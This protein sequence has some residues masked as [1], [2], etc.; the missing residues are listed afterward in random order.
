[1]KHLNKLRE[2]HGVPP[3]EWSNKVANWASQYAGTCP[4]GHNP[5]S[6]DQGYGENL[7][8]TSTGGD[9][10]LQA[11]KSWGDEEKD[12]QGEAASNFMATGHYTQMVWKGTR[13]I[14]CGVRSGCGQMTPV[15]CNFEPPGKVSRLPLKRHVDGRTGR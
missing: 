5:S 2:N 13:K 10:L 4:Q 8:W 1:M 11:M 7:F 12:Y 14:G 3:V 9:L 15:V 6:Q